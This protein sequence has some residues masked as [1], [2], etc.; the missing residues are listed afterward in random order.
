MMDWDDALPWFLILTPGSVAMAIRSLV[1]DRRLKTQI[2]ALVNKVAMY[3][4]RL[5]RLDERVTGLAGEAPLPAPPVEPPAPMVEPT[6]PA[7]E[8]PPPAQA[9]P[10]APA[11]AERPAESRS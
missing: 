7:P 4:H 5:F 1:T 6:Q 8:I 11:S 3:E 9:A 10:P 2:E